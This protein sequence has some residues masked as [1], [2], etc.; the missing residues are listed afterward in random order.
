[1]STVSLREAAQCSSLSFRTRVQGRWLLCLV[2]FGAL[3]Q[4]V[5]RAPFRLTVNPLACVLLRLSKERAVVVSYS[6]ARLG[7]VILDFQLNAAFG[8]ASLTSQDA[9]QPRERGD[10]TCRVLPLQ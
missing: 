5:Q 3:L 2:A 4:R 8:Y 7:A 9:L 6:D 1:M 10:E